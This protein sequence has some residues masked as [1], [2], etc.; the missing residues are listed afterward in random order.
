MSARAG[1]AIPRFLFVLLLLAVPS[2]AWGQVRPDSAPP[3]TTRRDTLLVPIPPESLDPDTVPSDSLRQTPESVV[4]NLFPRYPAALPTGF[5]AARWEW[6]REALSR[7]QGVTLL[8]FLARTPGLTVVRAGDHGQPSGLTALGLGGGRLRVYVDGFEI[9]PL[10]YTSLDVQQIG[11]ADLETLRVERDL[12]GIRIE[13]TTMRLP[14]NRPLSAIEAGTGTYDAKF[15]RGMLVRGVGEKSVVTAG[16]DALTTDGFRFDAP[17]SFVSARAA[18]SYA[19]SARTGF[20]AEI[21]NASV[22][23]VGGPY[24]ENYDRR[25]IL[26]RGRSEVRP[27]LMLDAALG[28][29]WRKP[30]DQDL[31]TEEVAAVQ[32]LVRA[33]YTRAISWF[34][35]SAR[36]RDDELTASAA[37]ALELSGRAALHPSPWL[38]TEGELRT[39][40]LGE[41]GSF[42]WKGTARAG[43]TGAPSL[44]VSVAGGEQGVGLVR[45]E[46]GVPLFSSFSSGV[47][48]L[49]FGAD[50]A[51][52][53]F[54][55]GVAGVSLQGATIAPFG[56]AFDRGFDA[57]EA[58]AARGVETH[59]ALRVP[60][61]L[62]LVRIEGWANY[63]GQRGGRPYLP[64]FDS[65]GAITAHGLFY[66]GQLEPTLSFEVR[67]RG[68]MLVPASD[69]GDPLL[70]TDPYTLTNLLFQ[71]RIL[72]VQ[73]FGLWENFLNYQTAEDI[74]GVRLPGQ[75]LIYGLRWIFRN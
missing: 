62:D 74:P 34:E 51:R 35:A 38:T 66:D 42:V 24:N 6:D 52:D 2:A 27:G 4:V 49:R 5:G 73:A 1:R 41:A 75:R 3:D 59:V 15:L 70:E 54:S 12:S 37:P 40:R 32:G 58:D 21:R 56:A 19:P 7:S 67:S 23:R 64:D 18:W 39:A 46:E 14:Q 30:A 44:F 63:W 11:L 20:Q 61:T 60:G 50:V 13:L 31:L 10:G 43:R 68:S 29:S 69:A 65:R 48:A 71:I 25:T 9:D 45:D 47:A 8:D 17:F 33:S 16:Y 36:F 53:A 22:E 55:I 28:R 72:D 57:V 26:L